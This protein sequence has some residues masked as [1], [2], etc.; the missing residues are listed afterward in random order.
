MADS[1]Y[2]D[3]STE[4]MEAS[5][6][7]DENKTKIRL[8][9]IFT[10]KEICQYTKIKKF[11]DKQ[12]KK[13][14]IK[15]MVRIIEGKSSISLRILDF[16]VSKFSKQRTKI[17]FASVGRPDYDV[18]IDYEAQLKSCKKRGFDPFKR[19][20]KFYHRYGKGK[21]ILTTIGQLNFFMWAIK[22][23][24]V[25]YVTKNKKEITEEMKRNTRKNKEKRCKKKKNIRKK[26]VVKAK[27]NTLIKID[28]FDDNDECEMV[29][30]IM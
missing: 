26:K 25:E 13:K 17:D 27:K 19:K 16:F 30:D 12:C 18:R 7:H 29:L 4:T 2:D 8:K 11:F 9:D 3:Y 22:N 6:V 20:K 5:S 24:I 21:R 15:K 23:K 28:Q 1:E 10:P 14:H